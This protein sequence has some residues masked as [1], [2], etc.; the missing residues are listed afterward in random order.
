MFRLL[1]MFSRTEDHSGLQ[2]LMSIIGSNEGAHL[3]MVLMYDAFM[4][5]RS[6]TGTGYI[7]AFHV[8]NWAKVNDPDNTRYFLSD[9]VADVDK[10][11]QRAC[12]MIRNAF[13]LISTIAPSESNTTP[14]LG[15][16]FN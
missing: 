14:W 2:D 16:Y 7:Q 1:I 9:Y 10:H 12:Q 4:G 15:R 6:F 13:L 3:Q 5:E 8:A 11:L